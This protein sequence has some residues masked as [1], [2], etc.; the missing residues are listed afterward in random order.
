MSS[1][2]TGKEIQLTRGDSFFAQISIKKDEEEYIPQTGDYI[3]FA[4]KRSK[5][6][7]DKSDYIDREPLILKEIPIDTM[8]L[9]LEPE[10]TKGLPFGTYVYDIEITFEDGT[11]DTFITEA[12]FILTKEVY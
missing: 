3:R 8:L 9:E 1:T 7:S 5:L 11:V 4:L 10:D 2:I 12:K 6:L